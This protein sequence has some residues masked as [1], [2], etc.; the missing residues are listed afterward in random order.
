MRVLAVAAVLAT[1]FAAPASADGDRLRWP[2]RPHPPVVRVFDAPTPNW[3]RGHR[4]V[5]LA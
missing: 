4:G 2:L 1:L 5:D 3:Q